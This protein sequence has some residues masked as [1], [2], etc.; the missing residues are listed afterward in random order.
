L[1]DSKYYSPRPEGEA[2]PRITGESVAARTPEPR[3]TPPPAAETETGREDFLV[4]P[5]ETLAKHNRAGDSDFT[6]EAEAEAPEAAASSEIEEPVEVEAEAVAVPD[7]E[8]EPEAAAVEPVEAEEPDAPDLEDAED[9]EPALTDAAEPDDDEEASDVPAGEETLVEAADV[10]DGEAPA[11][12]DEGPEPA[13]IPTSLTAALRDQ[14]PRFLH[15][16]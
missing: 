2:G 13:R 8:P 5:G 11:V 10:V 16:A 1:P 3:F 4:L 7:V 9:L 6:A 14:G 12:T 15:R